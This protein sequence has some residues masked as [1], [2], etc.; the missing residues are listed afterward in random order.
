MDSDDF[1]VNSLWRI[2][3]VEI[4]GVC[5]LEICWYEIWSVWA[6]CDFSKTSENGVS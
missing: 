1:F 6:I 4:D 2:I 5:L 3:D